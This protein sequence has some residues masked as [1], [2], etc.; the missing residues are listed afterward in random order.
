MAMHTA[1]LSFPL[2]CLVVVSGPLLHVLHSLLV[3]GSVGTCG[4][5]L[6]GTTVSLLQ[7]AHASELPSPYCLGGAPHTE[8]TIPISL[9]LNYY[10]IL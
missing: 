6:S 10:L 5:P 8:A 2:K 1:G 7:V 3:V 9:V 4:C